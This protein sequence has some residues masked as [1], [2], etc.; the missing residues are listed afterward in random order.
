MFKNKIVTKN[1][2]TSVIIVCIV[3]QLS[4]KTLDETILKGIIVPVARSRAHQRELFRTE[5]RALP[6]T[7]APKDPASRRSASPER[8]T[9]G[10]SRTSV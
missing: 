10:R 7:T 9:S 8:T 3:V 6:A 2:Y 5:E 4:Y 1:S